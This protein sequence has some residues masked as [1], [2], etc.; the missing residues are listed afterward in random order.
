MLSAR[1]SALLIEIGYLLGEL[2]EALR[3]Y[4]EAF[5][6]MG[7]IDT[8]ILQPVQEAANLRN[9]NINFPNLR[10]Y[11]SLYM[12]EMGT[13]FVEQRS[14]L[15][16]ELEQCLEQNQH[17]VGRTT[18]FF[19]DPHTLRAPGAPGLSRVLPFQL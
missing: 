5:T 8:T 13:S 2:A 9:F 10:D 16:A 11:R 6:I 7:S 3:I 19:D 12:P 15:L 17:V 14:Y 1:Q 18:Q 4:D